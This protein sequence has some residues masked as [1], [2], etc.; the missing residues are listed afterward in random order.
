MNRK[1]Y[2]K[3]YYE[4]HKDEFKAR[5]QKN[6]E[7]ISKRNAENKEKRAEY[8]KKWYAEHWK[9]KAEYNWEYYKR[10]KERV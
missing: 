1:E 3:I 7:S 2:A 5:Y 8:H 4:I 9:E 10:R 6:R